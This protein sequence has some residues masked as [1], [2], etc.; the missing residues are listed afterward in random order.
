MT[1]CGVTGQTSK[2]GLGCA[3]ATPVTRG[4][5]VDHARLLDH[6]RSCLAEGC[7]RLAIFGTTGEGAS[8]GAAE[9]EEALAAF[10]KASFDPRR[11]VG[12]VLASTI[13]EAVSQARVSLEAKCCGVLMT[14][15]FYFKGVSD[16]GLYAWF[17]AVFE[18]LGARARDVILYHIPSVTQVMLSVELVGRLRKNFPQVILGVKDSSGDW[19][20]TKQLLAAHHDLAILV[21]DERHLAAAM[22]LGAQG[23]ISGFANIGADLMLPLV[24][25]GRDDPRVNRMVDEILKCPVIPAV[26][27]LLAHRRGDREWRAARPPL[28]PLGAAL[29]ERLVADYDVMRAAEAA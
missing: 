15:P 5:G 17:A 23:C 2:F 28:A 8:F 4:G 16:N 6:A 21:G 25:E 11:M 19:N 12:G 14:P 29:T 26:K 20:Y 27:A 7:D 22:R 24:R 18:K 3:L 10:A 1:R 9:R 13:E